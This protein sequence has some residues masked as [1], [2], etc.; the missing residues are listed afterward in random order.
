MVYF[1]G[2]DDGQITEWQGRMMQRK[3]VAH[4][5]CLTSLCISLDGERLISGAAHLVDTVALEH[6]PWSDMSSRRISW[7]RPL[8]DFSGAPL[9]LV[10]LS[11]TNCTCCEQKP[12]VECVQKWGLSMDNTTR[13]QP[14]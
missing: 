2:H 6:E 13:L 9:P 11:R 3:F 10:M 1:T 8:G 7:A 14:L 4:K 5:G 12:S